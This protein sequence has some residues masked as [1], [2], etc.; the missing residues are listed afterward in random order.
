[1]DSLQKWKLL[2]SSK[3]REQK[4]DYPSSPTVKTRSLAVWEMVDLPAPASSFKRE[5]Y[6]SPWRKDGISIL[7]TAI[8]IQF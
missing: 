7:E 1:M 8:R 6:S 3:S 4:K 5:A 2:W